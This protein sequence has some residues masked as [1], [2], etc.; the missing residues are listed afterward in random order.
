MFSTY[1]RA[2]SLELQ[3]IANS[4]PTDED[5]GGSSSG[6]SKCTPTGDAGDLTVWLPFAAQHG[7][8]VLE[9]YT[10]DAELAFDPCFCVL[11]GT[12]C[13]T[14]SNA[15]CTSGSFTALNGWT[16]TQQYQFFQQVGLG[17][18]TACN[19]QEPSQSQT[20]AAGTCSYRD[21]INQQH[22][23]H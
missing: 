18:Q 5:C 23:Y 15:G 3:Q 10:V 11:N 6:Y 13:G 17:Y 16:S 4:D 21:T 14:G 12:S 20:G 19:P 1:N 2:N 9:L 7:M 22:A 8:N